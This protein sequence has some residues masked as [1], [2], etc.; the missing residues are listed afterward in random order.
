V[1]GAPSV[2]AGLG[3]AASG[4]S[5]LAGWLGIGLRGFLAG[6]A[7]V[8]LTYAVTYLTY[9][10]QKANEEASVPGRRRGALSFGP[11]PE[12]SANNAAAAASPNR[13]RWSSPEDRHG[14]DATRRW[15]GPSEAGL[16]YD[17]GMQQL[18]RLARVLGGV[19]IVDNVCY[20]LAIGVFGAPLVYSIGTTL[21]INVLPSTFLLVVLLKLNV[22]RFTW[23][24]SIVA[25]VI[26]LCLYFLATALPISML[27][28]RPLHPLALSLAVGEA[29]NVSTAAAIGCMGVLLCTWEGRL[30]PWRTVLSVGAVWGFG[31][32]AAG[33]PVTAI[34]GQ[35]PHQI[36]I[37]L[38]LSN[39][40]IL[41][42][43]VVSGL[44]G[45]WYM[46]RARTVH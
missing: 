45:A 7:V 38:W 12:Q 21:L 23:L 14:H 42:G 9:A 20:W 44:L 18:V 17:L 10:N 32:L 28:A 46:T 15:R 31:W 6:L 24:R 2:V 36:S 5:I 13:P 43:G 37:S 35:V 3:A 30:V 41:T 33:L 27:S 39:G 29:I 19:W 25:G 34:V 4:L 8:I 26:W 16:G 1:R 22:P 40:E 11:G